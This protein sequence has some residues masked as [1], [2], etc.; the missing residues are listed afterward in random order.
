MPDDLL[1]TAD[2]VLPIASPPIASG[3]VR[4]R[5][6]RIVEVG[7]ADELCADSSNGEHMALGEAAILPGLVNVHTHLELVGLRGSIEASGFFDWIR[8]LTR[9]KY[10]LMT[11][12]D[13]ALS[14]RWGVVEAT[15]AGVTTLGDVVDVGT[16][17][18]A[19]QE[20]GLRAI[21][22]QEAFGP[23]TAQAEE[24]LARLADRLDELGEGLQTSDGGESRVQ[25]GVSPHAPYTVSARLFQGVARLAIERGLPLSIHAAESR[26][27]RDFV[28]SASG[29][30]AE[31]LRS[32]G[33]EWHAVG[34]SPIA[35]LH[36]L[37]VLE[38]GPLLAHCV[39]VD[40]DDIELLATTAAKVAHC[41]KANAKLGHGIAPL[42]RLIAAGLSVGIGTD[43]VV[44]N[45]VCDLLDEARW[46]L[47]AARMRRAL[48]APADDSKKEVAELDARALLE[49]STLGGAQA[50]GLE[51]E[52]GSLEPGKAADVIAVDLRGVHIGPVH[53]VE[54][55]LIGSATARDVC[56][57]LVDGEQLYRDG[58]WMRHDVSA[59]RAELDGLR[60]RLRAEG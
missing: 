2:W 26:A 29:P 37:G 18:K 5:A 10:E 35:Y 54:T 14:A 23:D 20:G 47:Y 46:A 44:C 30:F 15:A 24:S 50:L 1:L 42:E 19:L 17:P 6:G 39:D 9:T 7:A 45:N 49:R 59:L 36:S 32:R 21:C 34:A 13:L 60:D 48:L 4:I 52:V 11:P 38:T 12:E 25:L 40:E 57:T 22:Y 31:F 3:A 28:E 55:A 53:D 16:S 27:E 51:T 43:G 56:L 33:I 8:R 41:P 58:R